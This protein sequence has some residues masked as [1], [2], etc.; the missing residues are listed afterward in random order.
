MYNTTEIEKAIIFGSR[1]KGNYKTA[2][3]IDIALMG[4]NV[5]FDIVSKV[6]YKLQEES[7][8]HYLVDIIDYNNINNIELKE[9]IDR[10]GIAIYE[11]WFYVSYRSNERTKRKC[12]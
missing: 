5:N 7:P 4:V 10:V 2:S 3:D 1:A 8:L 6:H 12:L 9:R 11:R